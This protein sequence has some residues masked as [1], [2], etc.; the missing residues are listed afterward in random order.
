MSPW[1][2]PFRRPWLSPCAGR[3]PAPGSTRRMLDL[4]RSPG[5]RRRRRGV[6][7]EDGAHRSA[8]DRLLRRAAARRARDATATSRRGG[9]APTA[10]SSRCSGRRSSR[11]T[12]CRPTSWPTS[13]LV[14]MFGIGELVS[15]RHR[16]LVVTGEPLGEPVAGPAIRA[17]EMA[18]ALSAEHDVRLVSTSGARRSAE[19]GS[20]RVRRRHRLREPTAWADVVIFQGF[21]LE[22]A[23]WLKASPTVI[24]VG[25]LRPDA[26]RDSSS[27]P[28]TWARRAAPT[29]GGDDP[30]AERA[31]EAGRLP[32]VRL[33]EAARLL[34]RA[35]RRAGS[36][37]PRR[38]RRGRLARQPHRRRA[39]RHPRRPTRP[40]AAR[41]QGHGPGDR[42][43][44]QGH[45]LGRRGLQLVRPADPAA[46]R[47]TPRRPACRCP[48]VLPRA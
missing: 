40:A 34:A 36:G 29:P 8:G 25:R 9:G 6:G 45:P 21:L 12:G 41:D 43:G 22:T 18:T 7:A 19:R 11:H 44:G 31:A 2:G 17:W 39:V 26:P 14:E 35:A 16:I 3:S 38:L 42:A 5:R 4:Q 27:R 46:R 15:T 10:T 30:R 1:P 13:T 32:D 28:R 33:G 20:G 47:A 23:P 48:A 37:Q 24:V